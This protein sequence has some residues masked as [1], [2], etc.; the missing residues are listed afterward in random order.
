MKI[1]LNVQSTRRRENAASLHTQ[2][3][4]R[5]I[6]DDLEGMSVKRLNSSKD[7]TS[8]LL[9]VVQYMRKAANNAVPDKSVMALKN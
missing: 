2:H 7:A 5:K 9:N 6:S 8:R 4:L 1:H 3:S